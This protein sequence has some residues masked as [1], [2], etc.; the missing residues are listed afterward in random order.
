MVASH[1]GDWRNAPE[2]SLSAYRSAMIMG[3]DMIEVDLKMSKDSV[4]VILHDQTLNRSTTGKG[5]PSDFTLAELKEFRLRDG[6]GAPT[7]QQIPTLEEVML[8]AKGKVLVNLDHAFPFFREAYRVLVKTGTVDHALFKANVEFGE[9]K[10]T[11]PELIGKIS[12]M[13][14]VVDKPGAR[15]VILEYQKRMK[16]VAVELVFSSDTTSVIRD[17]RF[18]IAGGSRLWVNSLWPNISGGHDDELAVSGNLRDS[19]DWLILHG[20]TMI[21]TDRPRELL[22]YLRKRKLHD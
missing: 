10:S 7:R 12:Y 11:Y 15:S 14:V 5:K 8:L 3:V 13:P 9:L 17:S 1:R 19:W 21:Q 18:L 20:A 4:L 16:P 6:L 22:A 2:N